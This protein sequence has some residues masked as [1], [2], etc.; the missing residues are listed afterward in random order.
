MTLDSFRRLFA[1]DA[2]GNLA[3]LESIQ[4]GTLSPSSR[5][6]ALVGHLAGAGRLWLDRLQGRTPSIEIWPVLSLDE[7]EAAFKALNKAWNEYLDGLSPA[8][9]QKSVKYTN[10]KGEEWESSVADILTHVALHGTYHR[11]Q[12]AMLVR[13]SGNAPAYT[14]YIEATRRG[15]LP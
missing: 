7:C 14:D 11:G 8:D 13:Q 4:L 5:A 12:I 3:T 9:L 1:Y 2:W 15:L 6:S 10:S